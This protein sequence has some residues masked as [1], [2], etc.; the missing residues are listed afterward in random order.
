MAETSMDDEASIEF[1]LKDISE[2]GNSLPLSSE[3]RYEK[4]IKVTK[5]GLR[6]NIEIPLEKYSH[7]NLRAIKEVT[8]NA[9]YHMTTGSHVFKIFQF[10]LYPNSL[11]SY[12]NYKV[13]LS[14]K[15]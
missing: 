5:N 4:E 12:M 8:F 10:T 2:A 6:Q 1:I 11:K 15:F 7:V 9:Q 3:G 13:P 14:R